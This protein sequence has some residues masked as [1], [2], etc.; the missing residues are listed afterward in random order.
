MK[1][2]IQSHFFRSARFSFFILLGL[3]LVCCTRKETPVQSLESVQFA[4][5][6]K[7]EI[8]YGA[9]TIS[10]RVQFSKSPSS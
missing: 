5:P 1:N 10:F 2:M 9:G 3:C 7:M 8:A 6:E 4:V